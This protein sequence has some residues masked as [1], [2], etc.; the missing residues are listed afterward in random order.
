MTRRPIRKAL[1]HLQRGCD[2]GATAEFAIIMPILFLLIIAIFEFG[3]VYWINNTLQFAA[4]QTGRCILANDSSSTT[5][6]I[7][8]VTSA[9]CNAH[10][11]LPSISTANGTP[12]TTQVAC[13]TL[14]TAT[15][16]AVGYCRT[17]TI[18]YALSGDPLW[19]ALWSLMQ[20]ATRSDA[21]AAAITLRGFSQVPIG[22][23]VFS[24]KTAGKTYPN[25]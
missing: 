6:S 20:L 8:N 14:S 19:G 7:A 16:T 12:A 1:A 17:V 22:Y 10:S 9:P 24:C 5:D 18:D 15:A 21:S 11:Y 25:C 13:R 23:T 2:G 4:E 3:K